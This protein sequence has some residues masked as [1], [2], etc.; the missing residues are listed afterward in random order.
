MDRFCILCAGAGL[1]GNIWKFPKNYRKFLRPIIGNEYCVGAR[2]IKKR[3]QN[4]QLS[5][6]FLAAKQNHNKPNHKKKNENFLHNF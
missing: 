5:E 3:K 1:V 2:P 6:T 4:F